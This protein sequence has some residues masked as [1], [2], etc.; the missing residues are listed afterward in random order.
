M[1]PD[2]GKLARATTREP[3]IKRMLVKFLHFPSA[4]SSR[5]SIALQLKYSCVMRLSK[6]LL[7]LIR[8]RTNEEFIRLLERISTSPLASDKDDGPGDESLLTSLAT[9]RLPTIASSC[10]AFDGVSKFV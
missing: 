3:S 6:Y 8:R 5:D 2:P 7:P 1:L 10:I 9:I 4:L